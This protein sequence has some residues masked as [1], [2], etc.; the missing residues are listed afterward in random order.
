MKKQETLRSLRLAVTGISLVAILAACGGGENDQEENNGN[1]GADENNGADGDGELSGE[2][3]VWSWNIA[4]SSLELA[5][6]EFMEEHPDVTIDVQ[7]SSTDDVV[8]QLTVALSGGA[9]LPDVVSLEA[10][11]IDSFMNQFP[12]G[13]MNLSER[14][15][16]EYEDD[17]TEFK[18]ENNQ[19]EDGDFVAMPWDIGPAGVFYRVDYFE[20]AGVNPDEIETWDDFAEAGEQIYDEVGVQMVSQEVSSDD[21]LTRVFANQQG[22]YYFDEEG[23]IDIESDE[24]ERSFEV[25]QD[26]YESGII[27]N[28]SNWDSFVSSHVN[29]EVATSINGV[30]MSGTLMDQA[31]DQ[32]GLWDVF[33]LPVFEEEG[34]S[35]ANSGGSEIAVMNESENPDVAYAFAE[36]FTTD[37]DIQMAAF[38]EYGLFPSLIETY[39]E[40]YFSEPVGYFNE[41]AIFEIFADVAEDIEPTNFTEDAPRAEDIIQD[42]QSDIILEGSEVLPGLEDAAN[43]LESE[44]GRER[45]N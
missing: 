2:I 37:V 26:M 18:V 5:A 22:S 15:F 12:D 33:E 23:N 28:A 35:A 40:P 20:E 24:F 16:D 45:N 32:E 36:F 9:G 8:E 14:G 38:E 19:N 6:E 29:G 41:S 42:A 1:D 4:A 21:A 39:D 3:E 13:F 10:P 34:T 43:R 25:Y 31:D 17:F 44:T 7:D 11:Q 27:H 30:W